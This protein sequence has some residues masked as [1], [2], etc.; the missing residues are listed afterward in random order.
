VTGPPEV[1]L[2]RRPPATASTGR[3]A[4]PRHLL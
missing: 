4:S 1:G 3:T 2:G